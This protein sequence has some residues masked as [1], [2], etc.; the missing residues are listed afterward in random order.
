MVFQNGGN[1]SLTLQYLTFCSD[2]KLDR[3]Y[4]SSGGYV[5]SNDDIDSDADAANSGGDTGISGGDNKGG[6]SGSYNSTGSGADTNSTVAPSEASQNTT[7]LSIMYPDTETSGYVIGSGS[8][9]GTGSG[10]GSSSYTTSSAGPPIH[11]GDALTPPINKGDLPDVA[12][13][14]TGERPFVPNV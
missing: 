2:A 3:G 8:G 5:P 4:L 11:D 12:E 13:S 9:N 10:S 14:V 7:L 1:S 6:S